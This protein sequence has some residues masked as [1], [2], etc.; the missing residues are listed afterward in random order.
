[1]LNAAGLSKI[2]PGI[3]AGAFVPN[4]YVAVRVNVSPL[5][6]EKYDCKGIRK[7]AEL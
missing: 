5:G 6:S 4:A 3:L 1:M 2:P 7:E